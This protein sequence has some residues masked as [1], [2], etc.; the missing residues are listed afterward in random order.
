MVAVFCSLA[1]GTP[2][3]N[4]VKIHDTRPE[5]DA[6]IGNVLLVPMEFAKSQAQRASAIGHCSEA[7][8]AATHGMNDAKRS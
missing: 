2:A 4:A 5:A 8:H 6:M 3:R 7:P 1:A